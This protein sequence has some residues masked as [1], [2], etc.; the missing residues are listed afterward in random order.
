M[1]VFA[2]HSSHLRMHIHVDTESEEMEEERTILVHSTTQ[3]HLFIQNSLHIVSFCC[4]FFF[5]IFFVFFLVSA[6]FDVIL[7][8]MCVFISFRDM[9]MYVFILPTTCFHLWCSD[10]FVIHSYILSGKS[11]YLLLHKICCWLNGRPHHSLGTIFSSCLFCDDSIHKWKYK[12]C[13]NCAEKKT[14]Y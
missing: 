3:H 8:F 11:E 5:A 10:A 2:A 12:R 6:L 1:P 9:K 7:T 13:N 14:V 4:K